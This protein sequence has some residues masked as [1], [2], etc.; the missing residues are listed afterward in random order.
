MAC[1]ELR[2]SEIGFHTG[3]IHSI[4]LFPAGTRTLLFQ[5]APG[6]TYIATRTYELQTGPRLRLLICY[7][8]GGTT[9]HSWRD[10]SFYAIFSYS[11]SWK[12]IASSSWKSIGTWPATTGALC[13][14][15]WYN[16]KYFI[17]AIYSYQCKINDQSA[18]LSDTLRNSVRLLLS[19][20]LVETDVTGARC[21]FTMTSSQWWRFPP[22]VMI[23]L[24]H[25]LEE[26]N[27]YIIYLLDYFILRIQSL[28]VCILPERLVVGDKLRVTYFS[29]STTCLL[30]LCLLDRPRVLKFATWSS[31]FSNF[32]SLAPVSRHNS[33]RYCLFGDYIPTPLVRV[34]LNRKNTF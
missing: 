22:T 21:A 32:C 1:Q 31:C 13:F 8:Y 24:L 9:S 25:K 23:I 34:S 19:Y 11:S 7:S 14:Q 26:L 29:L 6:P 28:S 5:L 18:A 15:M 16:V 10:S 4:P 17:V 30:K 12:S 20:L 2:G 3:C 33:R 27:F